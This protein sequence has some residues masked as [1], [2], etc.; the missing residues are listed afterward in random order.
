MYQELWDLIKK[1]A[2]TNDNQLNHQAIKMIALIGPLNISGTE[3]WERVKMIAHR[4]LTGPI[5]IVYKDTEYYI[6]QAVIQYY[7]YLSEKEKDLARQIIDGL[8][9]Q[10]EH[11]F[12]KK[13]YS[14]IS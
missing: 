5:E 4:Y 13:F 12:K 2:H 6:F 8:P 1:W 9:D 7:G 10:D 3:A 11:G 14:C